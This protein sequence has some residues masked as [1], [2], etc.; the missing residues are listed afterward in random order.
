MTAARIGA[1]GT[2]AAKGD[3]FTLD[4][5]K[6]LVKVTVGADGKTIAADSSAAG[7]WDWINPTTQI[8]EQLADAA[9][10]FNS[11]RCRNIGG[12]ANAV[13]T[14][15]VPSDFVS[16]VSI[17]LMFLPNST[18]ATRSAS[19]N[20][21]Y[22]IAGEQGN[23]HA[24]GATTIISNYTGGQLT[25]IDFTTAYSPALVAGTWSG[26]LITNVDASTMSVLGTLLTYRRK[27]T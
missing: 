15:Y 26:V 23:V 25:L 5:N 16:L 21:T 3:L 4:A 22:G 24:P 14:F 27:L 17:S 18:Q 20:P 19:F 7:G 6:R 1:L 12:G 8:H 9:S 2:G 11:Y 10:A 13:H